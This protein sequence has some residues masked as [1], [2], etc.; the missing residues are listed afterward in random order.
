MSHPIS[1]QL[2]EPGAGQGQHEEAV[3]G[4]QPRQ[5]GLTGEPSSAEYSGTQG[6]AVTWAEAWRLKRIRPG[7]S[8]ILVWV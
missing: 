7:Y 6:P 8:Q 5:G 4:V 2:R 3:L 1:K